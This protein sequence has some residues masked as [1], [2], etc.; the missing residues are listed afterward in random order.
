MVRKTSSKS[1]FDDL[2]LKE[3]LALKQK[4]DVALESARARERSEVKS[5]ISELAAAH[6][7]SVSELFGAKGAKKPVGIAKYVNP[8][9]ANDTWTGRGRKPNW[10]VVR[11]KKGARLDDF[12]I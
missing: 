2:S 1:D 12:A 3:L 6:G 7:L 8:E 4:I 9:D 11:L 10:L 5:R